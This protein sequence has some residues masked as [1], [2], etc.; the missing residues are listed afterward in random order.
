[1]HRTS[2]SVD[3]SRREP[4]IKFYMKGMIKLVRGTRWYGMVSKSPQEYFDS[5]CHSYSDISQIIDKKGP[6]ILNDIEPCMESFIQNNE[7]HEAMPDE[8]IEKLY[9]IGSAS[10][11]KIANEATDYAI[12]NISSINTSDSMW[13][14]WSNIPEIERNYRIGKVTENAV[15]LLNKSLYY[16]AEKVADN[17]TTMDSDESAKAKAEFIDNVDFTDMLHWKEHRGTVMAHSPKSVYIGDMIT[18]LTKEDLTGLSSD[19]KATDIETAASNNAK[20]QVKLNPDSGI[21]ERGYRELII[22]IWTQLTEAVPEDFETIVE[23]LF[24]RMR[25]VLSSEAFVSIV[26]GLVS[27]GTLPNVNKAASLESL[28]ELEPFLKGEISSATESVMS[29]IKDHAYNMDMWQ[30][31]KGRN[32]LYIAGAT[33]SV[34][35]NDIARRWALHH[36]KP[37]R[38]VVLEPYITGDPEY[39]PHA[40]LCGMHKGA[41]RDDELLAGFYKQEDIPGYCGC[42]NLCK[43]NRMKRV[44]DYLQNEA[45]AH[46]HTL[47]VWNGG[48]WLLDY[49]YDKSFKSAPMIVRGY[50][51]P[52]VTKLS[53]FMDATE[54]ADCDTSAFTPWTD[55]ELNDKRQKLIRVMESDVT[56]E[57]FTCE[58]GDFLETGKIHCSEKDMRDLEMMSFDYI[59]ATE[60][61]KEDKDEDD[62]VEE[63]VSDKHKVSRKVREVAR[64]GQTKVTAAYKKYKANE[65]DVDNKLTKLV[66]TA[67][68]VV[69]GDPNDARRQIVEGKGYSVVTIL[70]QVLGGYAIFSVSKV[71]FLLILITRWCNSGK[72]KRAEKKKILMELESELD[73]INEKIKDADYDGN[74]EAKYALMRNKHNVENAITRIKKNFDAEVS[75]TGI[76]AKDVLVK[77]KH[78]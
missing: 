17:L 22:E 25:K 41:P 59:S 31:E 72:I 50:N 4:F 53:P 19:G 44:F 14:I 7:G 65:E 27:D 68:N 52:K 5:Y 78:V 3:K 76:G 34:N 73:L 55:Q 35:A 47:Y 51:T 9:I 26:K 37:C 2:Y 8:L 45:D 49:L 71:A 29:R 77:R 20:L 56:E 74:R 24:L 64:K 15:D 33:E 10:A 63:R 60:S 40:K 61:S 13:Y 48:P 42:S 69:F 6:N 43:M 36:H 30:A 21:S 38:T 62:D 1:M 67:K 54:S 16:C 70:K 39:P 18:N 28:K 57:A 75:M 32:I 58:L 66:K 12:N 23:A 11:L 46:P